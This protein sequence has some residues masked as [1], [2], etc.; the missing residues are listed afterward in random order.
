M[1]QNLQPLAADTKKE[2]ELRALLAAR[3]ASA[4]LPNGE[5]VAG[6]EPDFRIIT[7]NGIIGVEVTELMPPPR[8]ATFSSPVAEQAIHENTI[9]AAERQYY[10]DENATPVTVTVNF[11]TVERGKNRLGKMATALV[12]FVKNHCHEASP[13]ATFGWRPELPDGFDVISITSTP[14]PWKTGKSMT[15]R[16]EDIPRQLAATIESKNNLL[17]T[18]RDNVPGSPV[19]LLIY[20]CAEVGR[21]VPMPCGINDWTFKF[22]FDR[23]FFYAVMDGVE[24]IRKA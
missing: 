14:G 2:R 9:R 20:S 3:Q 7:E 1:K 16:L 12:G 10:A 6:E 22:D 4:F 5:G 24:E 23:V 8:S 18:Y 13:V 21:S 15:I 17:P 19:W 11:W